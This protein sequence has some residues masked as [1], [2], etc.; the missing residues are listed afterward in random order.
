MQSIKFPACSALAAALALATAP[1]M[2]GSTFSETVFIGDSL[3]DSGHFRPALVQVAGPDAAVLGRFTTNPGWVWAEFLADYYGTNADSDN[4]GGTNYAVGGALAGEDRSSDFGPVPSL[5]TQTGNYL[6]ANGGS[7]DPNALYTVWGGANDLFA[8]AAG[9]PAEATIGAAITAQLGAIATLQGAGAQYVLVPNIPDL[10]KTPQFLA[11]GAAGVAAGTQLAATYNQALYSSLGAAGLRVI[12]LDT[13]SFIGEIAAAPGTYGFANVTGTACNIESSLTCSPLNYVDPSAAETYAFADG[14]HPSTA[15]HRLLA[16]YAV[17]VIEGPRLISILP[18]SAAV[19]GRGRADM[20]AMHLDGKPEQDG[21]RWWGG[22]RGDMQRYDHGDLYDGMA[23]SGSFGVDSVRGDWV[24][25]GFAG[26][27]K[28]TQDF[29][30]NSGD[31]SQSDTTLGGFAGW[32]GDRAWVNAQLSYSWLSYDV[33]RDVVLGPAVRSHHGSADG[34]NL[35]VGVSA[36]YRMGEGRLQHGPVASLLMQQIKVDGYAENMDNSTSLAYPDQ[37]LDSLTLDA[38]WQ[39]SYAINDRVTPYFQASYRHEFED[40]DEQVFAQLE[41]VSGLD[42][43]AVPG[44]DWDQD[45]G[46]VRLG[47]R[48]GLGELEANIGAIGTVGQSG[49]SDNSLYLTLGGRF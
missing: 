14:V 12:P 21:L 29:G 45:Y 7:A 17:S 19:V 4:Q 8:V 31:F 36:G 16:Q 18:H 20:V 46:V 10:G 38:G 44:V 11:Q 40:A 26:Y 2:A 32:Y 5:L 9:A 15:A 3:T 30:Q 27:G 41:S 49:G 28:G 34:S 42:A 25:G 47:A 6:A 39:V 13:F 22:L 48:I 33:K 24:F 37:D 43:Y 35:G 23:P 1:A